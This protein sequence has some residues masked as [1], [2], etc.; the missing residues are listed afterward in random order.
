MNGTILLTYIQNNTM[1]KFFYALCVTAIAIS[2]LTACSGTESFM[3]RAYDAEW[4]LDGD[5][6]SGDRS[7]TKNHPSFGAK[8]SCNIRSHNCWAGIDANN[9]GYCDVCLEAGYK[10]HMVNHH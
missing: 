6:D 8:K 4:D 1:K 3:S 2:L 5:G 9:D 10:C 7:G